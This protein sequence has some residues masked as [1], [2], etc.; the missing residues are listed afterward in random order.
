MKRAIILFY[1][2][3]LSLAARPAYLLIPMDQTQQNHLKAYGI[4]YWV[5]QRDVEVSWL[6]NYREEVS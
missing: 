6:L 2:L 3:F 4:A 1:V 5:L